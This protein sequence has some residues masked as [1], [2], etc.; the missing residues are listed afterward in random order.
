MNY[1]LPEILSIVAEATGFTEDELKGRRGKNELVNARHIY[2]YLGMYHLGNK[3]YKERV[4]LNDIGRE[5]S[6]RDHTTILHAI[7]NIEGF[8]ETKDPLTFNNLKAI[9]N[10]HKTLVN[11]LPE[12]RKVYSGEACIPTTFQTGL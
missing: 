12:C 11:H 9:G 3:P 1:T 4:S 10:K 8:I 7:R 6:D 5:I 2:C